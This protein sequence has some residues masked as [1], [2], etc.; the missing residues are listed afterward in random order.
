MNQNRTLRPHLSFPTQKLPEAKRFY[1]ALFGIGPSKA[2][3]DY[4]KFDLQEPP[5]NLSITLTTKPVV[6][7]GEHYGIEVSSP[8]EVDQWRLRSAER[9]L[10]LPP[11][12]QPTCCY[13]EQTKF[14][15]SDPDGRPWEVFAV[16][17][18]ADHL[19]ERSQTAG[20]GAETAQ[21]EGSCCASDC[22]S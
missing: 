8:E 16:S 13:A 10:K 22:C 9:G 7:T 18:D 19:G 6:V 5:L 3:E 21:N 11:L 20:A 12:Q 4:L 14:W 1:S 2:E 15:L 17:A